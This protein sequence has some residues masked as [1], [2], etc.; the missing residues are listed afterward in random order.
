MLIKIAVDFSN[1]PGPRYV[2]E[3]KFSGESFRNEH[4]R[5][6]VS[7]ALKTDSVLIIDLDGTYGYGT[8]FLEESFGGLIRNDGFKLSQLK[9]ILQFISKEDPDLIREIGSYL[10]DADSAAR[11]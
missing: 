11:E 7:K 8:S 2:S 3:G 5:P 10:A 4:L 9:P 6:M 1:T